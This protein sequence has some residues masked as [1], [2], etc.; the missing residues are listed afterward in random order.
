LSAASESSDIKAKDTK[1]EKQSVVSRPELKD[2]VL[3]SI[4]RR[5]LLSLWMCWICYQLCA[6]LIVYPLKHSGAS[7][8]V[9]YIV[10]ANSEAFGYLAA[11]VLYHKYRKGRLI[12]VAS[13][14]AASLFSLILMAFEDQEYAVAVLVCL[15]NFST[16]IASNATFLTTFD[17]FHTVLLATVF[18]LM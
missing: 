3:K 18:G 2:L 10:I 6:S 8:F 13:M 5:N 4:N 1:E 15:A 17:S 12:I 14:A 16:S 9:D 7:T 11:G